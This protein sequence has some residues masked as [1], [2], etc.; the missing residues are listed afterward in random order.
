MGQTKRDQVTSCSQNH[1]LFHIFC[2]LFVTISAT[3]WLIIMISTICLQ[4]MVESEPFIP[5]KMPVT[6]V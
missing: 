6:F 3:I 4:L 2:K 5:F 1:K